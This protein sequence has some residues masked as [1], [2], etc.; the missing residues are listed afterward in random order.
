MNYE[1]SGFNILRPEQHGCY[2]ADNIFKCILLKGIYFFFFSNLILVP[3]VPID[4]WSANLIHYPLQISAISWIV[5]GCKFYVLGASWFRPQLGPF[6]YNKSPLHWLGKSHQNMKIASHVYLPL[7]RDHLIINAAD[8]WSLW[9][10]FTI[11]YLQGLVVIM[12]SIATEYI[13]IFI[14]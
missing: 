1:A 2:L 10:S 12:I 8:R 5:N 13:L 3:K 9:R 4:N 11:V 14:I 7:L 6:Q